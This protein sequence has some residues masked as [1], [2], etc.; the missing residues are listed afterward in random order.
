MKSPRLIIY[1]YKE[2]LVND[3]FSIYV[4]DK[5]R[6]NCC[7]AIFLDTLKFNK[8]SYGCLPVFNRKH[9]F[10]FIFLRVAHKNNPL[11][12]ISSKKGIYQ[13]INFFIG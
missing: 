9:P 8:L 7:V 1:T 4:I 6:N 12:W 11:Y 2:D 5:K 13:N 3:Y 10:C